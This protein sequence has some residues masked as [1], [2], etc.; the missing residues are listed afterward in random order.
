VRYFVLATDYD[1]T[2]AHDGVTD[3]ATIAALERF[4][5]SGGRP[6]L[7]TGRELPELRQV[8]A[9]FDLFDRIVAENGG[10]MLDPVTRRERILGPPANARF[11]E[12]LRARGVSPLS[13]GRTIVATVEPHERSALDAI[14]SLGLELHVVFNK[15]AV[16]ML[17]SGVNK[18][19]GLCAAL[20]DL[21]LSPH[22][23]AG[24][25]D[26][27]NDH[28]FLDLCELSVAVANSIPSLLDHVDLV[29]DG[30]RGA[31][32]QEL[33]DRLLADE[34]EAILS[35]HRHWLSIGKAGDRDVAIEPHG[36]HVLI[37]G[38]AGS[39][40]SM[41]TTTL[42]EELANARYQFC[43][44]DPE[45]D[46]EEFPRGI[47]IGTAQAPPPIEEVISAL[48]RADQNVIVSLAALA[49]ADGPGYFA[50][51]VPRLRELGTRTG[52]PHWLIVDGAHQVLPPDWPAAAAV[53]QGR[54]TSL[55][56]VTLNPQLVAPAALEA[57]DVFIAI[58]EVTRATAR[59]LD[60]R[61]F[62]A[63][64]KPVPPG[65]ATIWN[66]ASGSEG[67][68]FTMRRPE[69]SHRRSGRAF[70]ERVR[71]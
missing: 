52:R 21:G 69:E 70:V 9:R 7:V 45:G 25:G 31:G 57:I 3:D 51:L 44:V 41:L 39:G 8:F 12:A 46:Y 23:V 27:E 33:I 5:A 37:C 68:L 28:A 63:D 20:E 71:Q 18:A 15:G 62:V 13:V 64:L 40:K 48:R 35:P 6:I 1:G 55:A 56:F 32:V 2:L 47:S 29:T 42:L 38:P 10:V 16:M 24:I 26:A 59:T 58:G 53:A 17:P 36:S 30:A 19:T 67:L 4:R 43:L 49:E 61:G 60:D 66:A 65:F 22:N 50:S 34:P 14:R 11:V 54:W